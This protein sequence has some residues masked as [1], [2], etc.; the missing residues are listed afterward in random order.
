MEISFLLSISLIISQA[1]KKGMHLY[2]FKT[3][4]D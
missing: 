1:G 4:L 2:H 3:F